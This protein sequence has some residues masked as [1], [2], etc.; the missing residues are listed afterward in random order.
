VNRVLLLLLLPF[1][2]LRAEQVYANFVVEAM[3]SA[4]LA[5]D[6]SGT[7]QTIT[8]DVSSEVKKNQVV[9]ELFNA[10]IKASLDVAKAEEA[11]AK[12]AY[13]Y[14]QKDF[15]RYAQVKDVIDRAKFDA[16]ELALKRAKVMLDQASANVAYREVLLQKTAIKAPFD[17]VISEK[18]IELGD[19]VSTASNKNQ[20][21]LQSKH[22]RK[23]ILEFDQKYFNVV[24][25]GDVFRYK[26]ATDE[27]E[28]RVVKIYPSTNPQNRKLKAEVYAKDILVGYF[29]DGY[30]EGK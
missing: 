13:E 8:V 1:V 11:S 21:K 10:D 12:I 23:L 28:G 20:L 27:H 7:I 24:S 15:D 5:F 16:M 19:V 4:S 29:G 6:A 3:Q 26:I 30:I 2:F 18:N 22:D 14:A 17:G 9:A 25:V